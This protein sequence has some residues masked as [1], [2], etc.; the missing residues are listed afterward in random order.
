M[1]AIVYYVSL[2][3]LYLVSLFPRWL[4]YGCAD[5]I[6]VLLYHVF[7]YRRKV[8][9]GNLARSFPEK[10]E[11]ERKDIGKKFYRYLCDLILETL[12]TLTMSPDF[13][14]RRIKLDPDA[15][16]LFRKYHS[17]KQS[18]ILVMGHY[19][20][21]EWAGNTFSLL[22]LHQLYVIYHPL[23]NKY[24][25][26]FMSGMR[27]RFGTRLIPMKETYREILKHRSETAAYAFI[28]DQTP[29]PENAYWTGFLNQD[30]P[31]FRGTELIARKTGYPV[32]YA[33]IDKVKRGF[34]TIR[35]EVLSEEPSR[36]G[37]GEISE[38]H[39]RLLESDIRKRPELWLWSHKRW[40]HRRPA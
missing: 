38:L 37:V 35:V 5:V 15:E 23:A 13:S 14:L 7:R 10:T 6:F 33:S 39:T 32:L 12:Q 29:P 16:A 31:V 4:L 18:V 24:F 2:P 8:V 36:T 25:D 30:T 20:N 3:F 9:E 40:K 34:Y 26:G 1:Q 22:G 11:R 28:A 19:G 21:W 27:K 17:D